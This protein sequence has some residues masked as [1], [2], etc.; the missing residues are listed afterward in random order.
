MIMLSRFNKPT[1][2]LRNSRINFDPFYLSKRP[3][4]NQFDISA[5][6]QTDSFS[7]SLWCFISF[8]LQPD[9]TMELPQKIG[10]LF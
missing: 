7:P 6:W 4:S 10:Q 3:R 2:M 9:L 1:Y 8:V 5:H